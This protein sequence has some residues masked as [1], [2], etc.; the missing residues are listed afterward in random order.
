MKFC[1]GRQRRAESRGARGR[2]GDAVAVLCRVGG[3]APEALRDACEANAWKAAAT[4]LVCGADATGAAHVARRCGHAHLATAIEAGLDAQLTNGATLRAY[5][6]RRGG[7]YALAGYAVA[8]RNREVIDRRITHRRPAP[9]RCSPASLRRPAA[10]WTR[11]EARA[12]R[13][14]H[15]AVVRRQK[16][17]RRS[18]ALHHRPRRRPDVLRDTSRRPRRGAGGRASAGGFVYGARVARRD[19]AEELLGRTVQTARPSPSLTGRCRGAAGR[20]SRSAGRSAS[21]RRRSSSALRRQRRARRRRLQRRR[22]PWSPPSSPRP[23]TSDAYARALIERAGRDIDAERE[24]LRQRLAAAP[25][26]N[27]RLRLGPPAERWRLRQRLAHERPAAAA[28]DDGHVRVWELVALK[29][30]RIGLRPRRPAPT[31]PTTYRTAGPARPK[32]PSRGTAMT[33][34]PRRRLRH[35]PA[36]SRSSPAAFGVELNERILDPLIC[37]RPGTVQLR[38]AAPKSAALRRTSASSFRVVFV[39]YPER[40]T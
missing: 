20:A 33:A 29:H 1:A 38:P 35:G 24:R 18:A 26:P 4:L 15:N 16:R 8:A 27:G 13:D 10:P 21:E 19:A 22:H 37:R 31:G 40:A 39:S 14:N 34:G 30:D 12:R 28:V 3:A 9:P 32:W 7:G 6:S 36:A 11:P 17:R 2:R 5:A 25:R 23:T